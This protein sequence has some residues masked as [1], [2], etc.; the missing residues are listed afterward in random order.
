M[1]VVAEGVEKLDH[2]ELL[3]DLECDEA[4]GYFFAKPMPVDAA[5]ALLE[6]AVRGV[7]LRA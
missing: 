7:P 4:Q 3:R 5:T 6:R 2:L 1:R